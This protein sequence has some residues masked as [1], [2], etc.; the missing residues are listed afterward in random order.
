M[1][2]AYPALT[3]WGKSKNKSMRKIVS[4]FGC[5]NDFGCKYTHVL[6]FDK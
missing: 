6:R 2:Y 5:L 1:A 4:C 3:G